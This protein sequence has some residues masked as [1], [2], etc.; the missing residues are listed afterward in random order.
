MNL[1]MAYCVTLC[2]HLIA[3]HHFFFPER[4]ENISMLLFM[5]IEGE[6]MTVTT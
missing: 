3:Y 6:I 5:Q 2:T 1:H 4:L